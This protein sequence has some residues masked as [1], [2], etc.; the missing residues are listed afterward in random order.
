MGTMATS[1][2]GFELLCPHCGERLMTRLEN[3]GQVMGCPHCRMPFRVPL[4][5]A[6]GLPPGMAGP[7]PGGQGVRFQ[8]QCKR[9]ASLLEG[10]ASQSGQEGMCPTCGGVFVVPYVDASTGL[11]LGQADPGDDGENPT[12]MHAYACAGDK[13]P[14]ILRVDD[15]TLMI[16]CARCQVRCPITSNNCPQCGVPFTI[17]GQATQMVT[18]GSGKGS[19]ALT[20]GIIA[21][22]LGFC[23]GP[24]AGVLGA[25]AIVL[26][27]LSRQEGA[28]HE[29]SSA[30]AGIV[31][32][33]IACTI[34]AAAFIWR[35]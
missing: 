13:A 23:I 32:G 31:L 22:L 33:I 35:L 6:S 2:S 12:P 14:R 17:E 28:T 19:S 4:P 24:Y 15:S 1:H 11:A 7:G 9:C 21:L 25:V 20:F 29:R 30:T 18:R 8:F 3:S 34:A 26:G 10:D 16:E 27:V 5:E